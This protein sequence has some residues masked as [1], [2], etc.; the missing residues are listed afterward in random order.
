M[1]WDQTRATVAP[2]S[3]AVA[4]AWSAAAF[5]ASRRATVALI[6]ARTRAL[7]V[8]DTLASLRLRIEELKAQLA[9]IEAAS[10]E[11]AKRERIVALG[12]DGG[13]IP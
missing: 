2:S 6:S 13:R 4:S 11:R 10:A 7:G 12:A 9:A 3:S 5:S 8:S 1:R